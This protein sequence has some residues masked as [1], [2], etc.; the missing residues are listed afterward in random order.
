VATLRLAGL[1][2][3]GSPASDA[4]LDAAFAGAASFM[5]DYF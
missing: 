5:L 2:M 4:Q 3:A 1:A